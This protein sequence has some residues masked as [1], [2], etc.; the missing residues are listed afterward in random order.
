MCSGLD[1]LFVDGFGLL[2][3]FMLG[4]RT[5]SNTTFVEVVDRLLLLGNN[6]DTAVLNVVGMWRVGHACFMYEMKLIKSG[7]FRGDDEDFEWEEW[8]FEAA[9]NRRNLCDK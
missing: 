1:F 3:G 5:V 8:R 7:V 9:T 4:M 2:G 6:V